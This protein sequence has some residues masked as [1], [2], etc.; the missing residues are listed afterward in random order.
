M[1]RFSEVLR[2][3]VAVGIVAYAKMREIGIQ[4]VRAMPWTVHPAMHSEF[5]EVLP[6]SDVFTGRNVRY[7]ESLQK[8]GVSA[9]DGAIVAH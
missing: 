4:D 8:I 2:P 6:R 7:T 1:E 3:V 9:V 5:W